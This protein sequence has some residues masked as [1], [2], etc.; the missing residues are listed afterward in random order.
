MRLP[1]VQF[2]L[3]SIM[4]A[5]VVMGLMSGGF[6]GLIRFGPAL[7]RAQRVNGDI[8]VSSFFTCIPTSPLISAIGSVREVHPGWEHPRS[9]AC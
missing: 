3:R 7:S 9:R 4:A 5:V 1:R 2:T 6:V 8:L